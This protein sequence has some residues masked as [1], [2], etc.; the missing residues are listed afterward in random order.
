MSARDCYSPLPNHIFVYC[1]RESGFKSTAGVAFYDVIKL[2]KR[3]SCPK[4]VPPQQSVTNHLENNSH[5]Q[6]MIFFFLRNDDV[7][8]S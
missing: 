3:I 4:L 7:L 5:L 2:S 8:D 6:R 1:T